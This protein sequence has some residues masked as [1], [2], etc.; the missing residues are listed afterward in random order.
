MNS[1]SIAL[2][3][4]GIKLGGE[5]SQQDAAYYRE[6]I[7]EAVGKIDEDNRRLADAAA[8]AVDYGSAHRAAGSILCATGCRGKKQQR[9]KS[10][11]QKSPRRN[12]R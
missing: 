9:T 6:A 10:N 3:S 7:A 12:E 5:P 8:A 2:S 11:R 4:E 1:S